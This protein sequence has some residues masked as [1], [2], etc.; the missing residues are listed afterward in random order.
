MATKTSIGNKSPET[1]GKKKRMT[2]KAITEGAC[3]GLI[4]ARLFV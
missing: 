2:V 1:Q 4:L 3:G